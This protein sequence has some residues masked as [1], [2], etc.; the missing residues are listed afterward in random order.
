MSNIGDMYRMGKGVEK[1]LERSFEWY[2]KTAVAYKK[3]DEHPRHRFTA[4]KTF[5]ALG[6]CYSQGW[7]VKRNNTL[8]EEFFGK[9]VMLGN[10]GAKQNFEA[11]SALNEK[12]RQKDAAKKKRAADELYEE[13]QK[14]ADEL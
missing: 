5:N 7:G 4:G 11:V 9:A 14:N 1:N 13:T 12:K 2:N 10:A 6:A 8:A 3:D